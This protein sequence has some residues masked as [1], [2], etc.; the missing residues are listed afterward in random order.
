MGLFD[1]FKSSDEKSGGPS[2]PAPQKS[3]S[4]RELARLARVAADKLAQDYDRQDA[5]AQLGRMASADAARALFRRFDWAMDPSITDQDEKE[6]AADGIVEAGDAALQPLRDYCAR[7][8]SLNWPLRILERVVPAERLTEELLG[9]LDQFDTEYVR[10]P[11]P[12]I[13]LLGALAAHP[14]AEVRVAV[15]PFLGDMAEP[16][17]FAA[18]D[19]VLAMND[20]ESVVALVPVLAEDESLRVR[21]R[22]ALGLSQRAWPVHESLRAACAAALPD[23][24]VLDAEGRVIARK[25]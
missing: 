21:N 25:A 4:P 22:I 13:Q 17:R 18:V 24:Y 10:N 6:A 1:F 14:C 5:I 23:G 3:A 2:K 7:A 8:D 19:A 9:L 11:E 15:E 20:R 16:V 12:K